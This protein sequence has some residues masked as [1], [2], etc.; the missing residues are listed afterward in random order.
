MKRSAVRAVLCGS[1]VCAGAVALASEAVAQGDAGIRKP[2][3]C[4][5]KLNGMDGRGLEYAVSSV[6]LG[7]RDDQFRLFESFAAAVDSKSVLKAP[8][9]NRLMFHYGTLYRADNVDSNCRFFESLDLAATTRS[10]WIKAN[11]QGSWAGN[12]IEHSDWNGGGLA[13]PVRGQGES[14]PKSAPTSLSSEASK[15]PAAIAADE[16]A[17]REA[18]LAKGEDE[19]ARRRAEFEAKLAEYER[20]KADHERQLREREEA[21]AEQNAKA[22]A[23]KAAAAAKL[24]QHERE[25]AEYR[26]RLAQRERDAAAV[27]A[28]WA[29]RAAAASGAPGKAQQVE[30][31]QVKSLMLHNSEDAALKSLLENNG[32]RNGPNWAPITNIQCSTVMDLGK[33]KWICT[34]EQARIRTPTTASG[35]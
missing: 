22:D 8:I 30:I 21:I 19:R 25:M 26:E 15:S 10:D 34:G 14:V 20:Q 29:T 12:L 7:N 18:E 5:A 3:F 6:M 16:R 1:W 31:R 32:A 11:T 28:E 27:R 13:S 17:A 4:H 23:A 35:Q 33:Q 9:Y 2:F 24:A